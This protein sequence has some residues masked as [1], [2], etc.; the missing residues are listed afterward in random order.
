MT[1]ATSPCVTESKVVGSL[2]M[3][4]QGLQTLPFSCS[5]RKSMFPRPKMIAPSW[6][7]C[8]HSIADGIDV[9]RCGLSIGLFLASL[10]HDWRHSGPPLVANAAAQTK[11]TTSLSRDLTL[12]HTH[13]CLHS[14][15]I[16]KR[17]FNTGYWHS[18][19]LS[20]DCYTKCNS[21]YVM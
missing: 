13:E 18:G 20:E 3:V 10:F 17:K 14:I 16:S 9:A 2:Q 4:M 19:S 5:P 21:S 1:Q 7:K 15:S 11:C 12:A 8:V 6:P